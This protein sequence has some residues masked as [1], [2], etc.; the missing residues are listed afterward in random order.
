MTN[1]IKLQRINSLAKD[2]Q[3]KTVVAI[4]SRDGYLHS[5]SVESKMK[6]KKL[7][8]IQLLAHQRHQK[9]LFRRTYGGLLKKITTTIVVYRFME[10]VRDL[11]DFGILKLI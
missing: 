8:S 4:A 7:D 9:D 2:L 1:S 11:L 3:R 5:K 10:N 6:S